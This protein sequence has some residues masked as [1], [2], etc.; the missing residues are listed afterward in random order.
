MLTSESTIMQEEFYL[1]AMGLNGIPVLLITIGFL[2]Y[3]VRNFKICVSNSS[4][5]EYGQY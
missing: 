1:L 4:S 5:S 2:F 3:K